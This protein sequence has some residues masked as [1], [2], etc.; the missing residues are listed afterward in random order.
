MRCAEAISHELEMAHDHISPKAYGLYTGIAV[1]CARPFD[2]G[3]DNPYG[4]LD[5]KWGTFPGRPE[6]RTRHLMLLDHRNKLLAH[7]DLTPHRVAVA[8]PSFQDGRPAIVEKRSPINADGVRDARELFVGD[9]IQGSASGRFTRAV[10]TRNLFM[11][12]VALKEMGNPSLLW[13]LDYIVLLSELKPE[14]AKIAALRWHG[15]LELEARS[16]SLEESRLALN[17]LEMLCAGDREVVPILKRLMRRVS[18]LSMPR[19]A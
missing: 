5:P 13:A 19:S 8:W 12:E 9:D 3:K 1:S 11:A 10:Q 4:P 6:L 18:P 16:M 7:N 15:R 2:A 17:A 14:K